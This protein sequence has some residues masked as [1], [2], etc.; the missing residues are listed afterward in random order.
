MCVCACVCVC[1]YVG[2][3]SYSACARAPHGGT[4]MPK[5]VGLGAS[6]SGPGQRHLLLSR[7]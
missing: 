2:A 4:D 6:G 5:E 3:E 7:K 1:V